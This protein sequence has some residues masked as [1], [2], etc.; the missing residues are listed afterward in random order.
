MNRARSKVPPCEH[1]SRSVMKSAER[2]QSPDVAERSMES[3]TAGT[4]K[5]SWLASHGIPNHAQ[6]SHRQNRDLRVG[7]HEWSKKSGN[8]ASAIDSANPVK[9]SC[10]ALSLPFADLEVDAASG[11]S[12]LLRNGVGGSSR[13]GEKIVGRIALFGEGRNLQMIGK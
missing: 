7:T 2:N 3:F 13:W 10:Q 4:A 9:Q 12:G 8:R 1:A 6:G 11:S 5:S